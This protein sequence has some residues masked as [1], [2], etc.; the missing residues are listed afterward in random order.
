VS[1]GTTYRAVTC[2]YD[3]SLAARERFEELTSRDLMAR[4]FVTL[5]AR[6]DYDPAR[7]GDP[8]KYPPLSVGERLE[9]LA[10]GEFLARTYRWAGYVDYALKAGATWAQI[11]EAAGWPEADVKQAYRNW[12]E[13]QHRLWRDHEGQ[14]AWTTPSTSK[15]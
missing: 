13:G 9:I 10:I 3:N 12:I 4:S 2:K 14:I 15:P 5:K 1:D 11:A 7:H 6:G 8:D